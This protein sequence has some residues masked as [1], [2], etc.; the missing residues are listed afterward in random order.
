M[1]LLILFSAWAPSSGPYTPWLDFY[2]QQLNIEFPDD[3][4]I[5]A[6]NCGSASWVHESLQRINNLRDLIDAP[7]HLEVGSDASG[8]QACLLQA[9]PI[10]SDYDVV[11]FV[12]TKGASYRW[13][14]Y[15][16]LRNRLSE[17]ILNRRS[18]YEAFNCGHT[19][20][21]SDRGHLPQYPGSYE[22]VRN[23]ASFMLRA[24]RSFTFA[25]T[26]T[27]FAISASSLRQSIICAPADLFTSNL[28]NL[29]FNRFFFEGPFP[30]VLSHEVQKLQ[31]LGGAEF[32][33]TL[34]SSV[35][36]D[37]FPSHNSNMVLAEFSRFQTNKDG[38]EPRIFPY[39]FGPAAILRDVKVQFGY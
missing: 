34:S 19:K 6:V 20:L 18:L 5:V 29:G 35:S 10:L 36:F 14:D 13:E 37:A 11:L 3:E 2:I 39:V 15:Q 38:F 26:F 24:P 1:R 25:A 33:S 23:L 9:R 21:V 17:T 32:Q 27:N 22:E 31:F 30:S 28:R 4:K 16:A 8:F 12:H 7:D